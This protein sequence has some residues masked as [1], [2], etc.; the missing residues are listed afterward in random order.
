MS[1]QLLY[2]GITA[3]DLKAAEFKLDESKP[4]S[5]QGPSVFGTRIISVVEG[6]NRATKANVLS[7]QTHTLVVTY[8]AFPK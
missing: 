4:T 7:S 1:A 5:Q 3:L 6:F 8:S 2:S